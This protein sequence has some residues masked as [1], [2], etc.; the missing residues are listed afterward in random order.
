MDIEALDNA[1]PGAN[2][3]A[4]REEVI[5]DCG[6]APHLEGPEEFRRL[7]FGFHKALTRTG[8]GA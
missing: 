1:L 3:G 2:G 7:L 4:Y 5:P 6:H 8:S